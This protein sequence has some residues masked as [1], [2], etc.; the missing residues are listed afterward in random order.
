MSEHVGCAGN[1]II[2]LRS[3]LRPW[4]LS[5]TISTCKSV[6]FIFC[7]R[8]KGKNWVLFKRSGKLKNDE[9]FDASW[10][11][12]YSIVWFEVRCLRTIIDNVVPD[13]YELWCCRY[14]GRETLEM[15]SSHASRL[16]RATMTVRLAIHTGYIMFVF[17]WSVKKLIFSISENIT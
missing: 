2:S 14:W 12:G 16:W 8:S 5:S 10:A 11:N 7:Q 6:L 3:Y 9:Y 15:R 13:C 4:P 1:G 17:R